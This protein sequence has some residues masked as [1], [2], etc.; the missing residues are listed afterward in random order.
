MNFP[1][2]QWTLLAQATLDGDAAGQGAL[3]EMCLAYRRPIA[4]FL[5]AR[6]HAPDEVEEVVQDF[7]LSWLKSRAW[8]RADR[9]QGKF[10][11]FLLGAVVHVLAHRYTRQ[12][13]LKRGGGRS[14]LSLEELAETGYEAAAEPAAA[15]VYTFDRAWALTLLEQALGA[16]EA[17][18]AA[19]GQA[20]AFEVLRRFL[21]GAGET[22]ALEDAATALDS[23]VNAVKSSVHRL[24]E[25]FRHLLRQAVARTVSVPHEVDEELRYLRSLLLAESISGN[26]ELVNGKNVANDVHSPLPDLRITHPSS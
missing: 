15:D 2:T 6:G 4:I 5:A 17:E 24:R 7:F 1:T 21:P 23:N 20:A 13:A 9:Q 12:Q 18:F 11:T 10:R 26:P 14:A 8:K 22:C 25:R 3:A 19:R 16:L